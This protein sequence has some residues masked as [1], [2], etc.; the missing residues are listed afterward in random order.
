M[1]IKSPLK[2]WYGPVYDSVAGIL[3]EFNFIKLNY[4]S[5]I[6]MLAF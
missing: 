2:N 4:T 6:E 1:N 3:A 5:T